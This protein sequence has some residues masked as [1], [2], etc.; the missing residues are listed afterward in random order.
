ME[1]NELMLLPQ[2]RR[3]GRRA[4]IVSVCSSNDFVIRAALRGAAGAGVPALIEA[5]ANQVNQFGGY[6]GMT[7]ADFA[8]FVRRLADREGAGGRGLLLGGDHLGPLC[9]KHEPAEQAMR[10]AEELVRRFAAAGYAKLHLDTSMRLGGDD[11]AAPLPV[12]LSAARTVR[13]VLALREA[14][15]AGGPLP[16]LVIGSEV[17]V[18]GGTA[19]EDEPMRVTRPEDLARTADTFRQAFCAAGLADWWDRVVA[20]VTQPG[21]EFG[22]HSVH[23]YDRAA[24]AALTE[25]AARHP[26]LVLEGHSTDYQPAW[27]LRQMVEDGVAILKVGP[28][29]TFHLREALFALSSI[30]QILLGP[31]SGLEPARFPQTLEGAML[32]DPRYWEGYY[33]GSESRRSYCRRYSLSDRCRYYL[34]VPE[35]AAAIRRLI[36]NLEKTEI[37]FALISQFMPVQAALVQRGTLRPEPEELILSRIGDCLETYAFATRDTPEEQRH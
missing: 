26:G 15:P 13:L 1:E 29:L 17:P 34:S 27:A 9:W 2:W 10:K 14:L 24:A 33:T 19:G 11:P 7:P 8:V 25:E 36:D 5:T 21:V 28:A 31:Q 35:V 4:G 6:T 23:L 22:D 30:E 37:P 18:P 16:V 20:V 32:R 3:Q 12:E